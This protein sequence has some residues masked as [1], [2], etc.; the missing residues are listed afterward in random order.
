MISMIEKEEIER[1]SRILFIHTGRTFGLFI[2]ADQIKEF[3]R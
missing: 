3:L 1:G 2:F